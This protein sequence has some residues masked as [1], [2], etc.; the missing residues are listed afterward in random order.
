MPP[1]PSTLAFIDTAASIVLA[2]GAAP[3]PVRVIEQWTRP[4]R[5]QALKCV[6]ALEIGIGAIRMC[7]RPG[8]CHRRNKPWQ[9]RV[10]EL[11]AA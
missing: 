2:R 1:P 6:M 4:I 9:V 8:Q 3:H 11:N 10:D 7:L 5:S